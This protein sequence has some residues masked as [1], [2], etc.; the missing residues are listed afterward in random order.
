MRLTKGNPYVAA[1]IL[2]TAAMAVIV[3]AVGIN[4]SAGLPFNLS[5]SWPPSHDYTLS[6][7]FTD[8]NGVNPGANV[9]IAGAQ[10]GQV[11]GVRIEHDQALVTMR[12]SR[13]YGPLH[14]GTVAS[15]RYST[16]LADKYIELTP[17][18]STALL[19]SG[20]T[21][22]SDQTVTPVDFDQFLSSLD[23]STR[24]QLQV[25]VQQLGGG[26][27]GEQAA[28][29]ALLDNLAGLS[30]QSPPVL[31]VLRLRDP[32][33]A[34][35]IGNLDTVA[36]RLAQSHQQLGQLVQNTALVTETLA[37]SDARLDD[38]LVHLA[39]VSQAT[40]QTLRGN[41]GNLQTTIE[42]LNPFLVQLNP[43]LTTAAGYLNQASPTLQAEDKYLLPAVVS[44]ISQQDANGNYLRQFVV[45]NTCDDTL[46]STP[47]PKNASPTGGC[48]A[49]AITG[50]V[51]PAPSH[52]APSK[53]RPAPG[54]AGRP[55]ARCPSPT[56]LPSP[57]VNLPLPRPSPTACPKPPPGCGSSARA[58]AP[59]PTPSPTCHGTGSGSGGPIPS[60]AP[61]PLSPLG[62]IGNVLGGGL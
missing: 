51:K 37:H 19:P 33:L 8:A 41:Q 56:P 3:A 40:S 38:L 6:A 21:I 30:E 7:A 42:R 53:S 25:L 48:L 26:V 13:R 62:P 39:S 35:I 34:S 4:L 2:V 31:N 59:T 46:A 27:A 45:I 11:T 14:R 50:L 12:I 24:Q 5:L 54:Q 49:Q 36:A 52:P 9:V 58:P 23:A 17:A 32:Q 15:I 20:A 22:P 44:A 55:G 60:P 28:I 43:Q 61:N 18:A 29:N 47:S 57:S 16:L 10:V 1:V